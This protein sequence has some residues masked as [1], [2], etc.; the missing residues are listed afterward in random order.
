MSDNR[1]FEDAIRKEIALD[2]LAGTKEGWDRDVANGYHNCPQCGQGHEAEDQGRMGRLRLYLSEV[3]AQRECLTAEMLAEQVDNAQTHQRCLNLARANGAKVRELVTLQAE[4]QRLT[5]LLEN[6]EAAMLAQA[7][8]WYWSG[9]AAERTTERDKALDLLAK[10]EDEWNELVS[11]VNRLHPRTLT[12]AQANELL[13]L[14][15][16]EE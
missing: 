6:A 15:R 7:G 12:D 2:P 10:A 13:A 3:V 8:S 11:I 4:N 16:R 9:V 1:K 5:D 14:H